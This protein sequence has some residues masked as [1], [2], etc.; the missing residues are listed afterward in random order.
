MAAGMGSRFGGLKQITPIGP[1]DEFLIDYSVYDAIEA[2]FTKIVFIIKRENEKVFRETIGHRVEGKIKVEYAYQ[3]LTDIPSNFDLPKTRVKPWG[4]GHAILVAKELIN[5]PFVVMN[6]DD[7]YGRDAFLTASKFLDRMKDDYGMVGYKVGNTLTE[8]GSVKRGV[9]KVKEDDLISIT[10]SK[11]ERINNRIVATPLDKNEEM[12]LEEDTLVSMNLFCFSP[13]IFPILEE[14]FEKFL[15][16]N[17]GSETKEY[18]IPDVV[19]ELIS[20]SQ[21]K[22]KVLKTTA[23]WYGVT[24]QE[25]KLYVEKEIKKLHEEGEYPQLL[26][27]K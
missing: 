23:K 26:W 17:I 3:D 18:L 25:D 21:V 6:A 15:E 22:V 12:Y 16:E 19:E 24:Y 5:A 8:N 27:K 13:S 9:C 1:N 10:E 11:V 7:F 20:T 4:T 14:G 2:G